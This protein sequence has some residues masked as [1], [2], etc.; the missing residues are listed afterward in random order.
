MF[1]I[2]KGDVADCRHWYYV[3]DMSATAL[4]DKA[5]VASLHD[6]RGVVCID[7]TGVGGGHQCSQAVEG[8]RRL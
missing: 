6:A 7:A 5:V 1:T 3:W 8:E 4:G 2:A